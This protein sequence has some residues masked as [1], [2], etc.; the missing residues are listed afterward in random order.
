MSRRA[1]CVLLA[2][3]WLL[4][5]L[6][7]C[8]DPPGSTVYGHA[9]L[10]GLQNHGGTT[11]RLQGTEH[12]ATTD[13][14][15]YFG[16]ENVP[17]G[18]YHVVAH[19]EGT[20]EREVAVPIEHDGVG[21]TGAHLV[22]SPY[23]RVEGHVTDA[24]GNPVQFATVRV[25]GT[26]VSS[27]SIEAGAF[28]IDPAPAGPVVLAA[29]YPHFEAGTA[30]VVIPVGNTVSARIS[31][32]KDTGRGP[33]DLNRVPTV[34]DIQLT[35]V[36]DLTFP[37]VIPLV[38]ASGGVVRR[39]GRYA[40]SV[41]ATD[42]DGD[43]LT[44]F[45]SADRGSLEAALASPDPED[46]ARFTTYWRAG[47]GTSTLTCTVLDPYGGSAT[48]RLVV[49]ASG[50]NI[51]SAGR[52]GNV[53]YYSERRGSDYDVYA[54]NIT[55]G[56][57]TLH[58]GNGLQQHATTVVGEWLVHA[59]TEF[60]FV[61]NLVYRLLTTHLGTGASQEFGQQFDH[62]SFFVITY[63]LYTPLTSP[64]VPFVSSDPAV[65]PLGSGYVDVMAGTTI[66]PPAFITGNARPANLRS[67]ARWGDSDAWVSTDRQLWVSQGGADPVAVA[68]VPGNA[69]FPVDLQFHGSR[70]AVLPADAAPIYWM[71]LADT[72]GLREVGHAVT[73]FA[74]HGDH[75][76][77]VEQGPTAATVE[78]L[79][80]VSGARRTLTTTPHFARRIWHLDEAYI[81][82]GD[83]GTEGEAFLDLNTELLWV[84]KL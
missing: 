16:F 23:G 12:E 36:P 61:S 39:G 62:D 21:A 55:T 81:I 48:A 9:V 35:A 26:D 37:Q 10:K 60:V 13:R 72:Q 67:F 52:H 30:E 71:D 31:L 44:V 18:N 66:Q 63:D 27:T 32:G 84:E 3:T 46:P 8:D 40:L 5:A 65:A 41:S 29:A 75:L 56:Q 64:F 49:Q 69:V 42:L 77:Y 68:S 7:A 45:F 15:G 51:R 24:A 25:L 20:L 54:Y 19:R 22:L 80:L 58:A 74:L 70:I 33:Y 59:N 34:T 28:V 78:L 11:V 50:D 79:N 43:P 17:A 1:G 76:A 57:E 14:Y 6:G 47:G 38:D 82:W 83:Q 73:S 4:A 53:V 2:A